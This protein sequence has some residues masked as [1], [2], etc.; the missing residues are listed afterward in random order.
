MKL[1]TIANKD[2]SR[3]NMTRLARIYVVK[4]CHHRKDTWYMENFMK[5][6]FFLAASQI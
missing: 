1:T 4:L 5:C 6:S 2:L 3:Q